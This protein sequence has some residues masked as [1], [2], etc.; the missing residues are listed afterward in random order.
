MKFITGRVIENKS[1]MVQ[2]M[3]CSYLC[4]IV[5]ITAKVLLWERLKSIA[6]WN[7]FN[8]IEKISHKHYD[9]MT[10][11]RFRRYWPFVRGKHHSSVIPLTKGQ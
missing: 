11:K 10:W 1:S 3:A 5:V 6:K 2:A 7:M 9:I 4:G 8:E